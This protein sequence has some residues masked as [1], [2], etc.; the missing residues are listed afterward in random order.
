MKKIKRRDFIF[1]STGV[2]AAS[3]TYSQLYAR[4]QQEIET[5][6]N[7]NK[8]DVIVLGV[9]SM[10]SSACY[11]LAKKGHRVLGLEQFDIPHEQG[12]HAG[13]SR[14]IRKAY[15]EHSDYVPL[16]ERSYAK[17]KEL[18]A[19][20][21]AQVYYKTGLA[22]FGAQDD[23][24]L[25]VVKE[26]SEKYK[27]PVNR[28]SAEECSRK[29]PQFKVPSAFQRLEE[30]EAGFVT[31]ERSVLLYT[32]QA[33]RKGAVIRTKEKV[34]EWKRTGGTVTVKTNAGTYEAKK[35]IITAGPWAAK[36]I[37]GYSTKL[38]ITRQAVAWVK[39]KK[40]DDFVL[41]KFPC[42]IFETNGFDFYGFPI[43]PVG[44]FGGPTGLK[45]ALHYP[46]GDVTDPD[47]VNRD[48]KAADQKVLV[49]FLK[50]FIPGGYEDILAMK[51]C[52]YTNSPDSNFI[53]DFLPGYDKDVAIATGF[54][55]HG[56]KFASVVGEIMSDL[57][58]NGST[59]QPIGFLNANRFK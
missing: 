27:I 41:G 14:L 28:L 25:K 3:L 42:W 48:T 51:T 53:I 58:I 38:T 24:F 11:H 36:M 1:K 2:A 56:F 12:S 43:L 30:P 35:L 57:A 20:T 52:L 40:W 10:G 7:E 8:F 46:G 55:G 23:A 34:L 49:D 26:S 16:L 19:E 6:S 5:P 13:Q 37:S 33:I 32:E 44:S 45:L 59:V 17:W 22:Y 39:P 9:G 18:E 54:S 50:E 15:G 29:Y 47:K 31:P 21:G 4:V